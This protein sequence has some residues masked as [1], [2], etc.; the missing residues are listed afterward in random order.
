MK[1][2]LTIYSKNF[3]FD[4]YFSELAKFC[5][6]KVDSSTYDSP[7]TKTH[8]LLQAHFSRLTLPCTDYQTD[9]K[10]VMDQAIRILQVRRS[11][12][13]LI[14]NFFPNQRSSWRLHG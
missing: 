4:F 7:H 14:D 13:I 12:V 10:T 6:I 11:G 5:K 2:S 8:L 3:I 1:N 9:L